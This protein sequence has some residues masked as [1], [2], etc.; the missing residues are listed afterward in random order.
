MLADTRSQVDNI[1]QVQLL[2]LTPSQFIDDRRK[3]LEDLPPN[4]PD[5][6]TLS[7]EMFVKL[8]AKEGLS[9]RVFPSWMHLA[10]ALATEYLCKHGGSILPENFGHNEKAQRIFSKPLYEFKPEI[11]NIDIG[12]KLRVSNRYYGSSEIHFQ[13]IDVIVTIKLQRIAGHVGY[14]N[15]EISVTDISYND[16]DAK[17]EDSALLNQSV[18]RGVPTL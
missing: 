15:P 13:P 17:L 12:V 9:F 8:I 6:Y 18:S 16:A 4:L 10:E 2:V 5:T 3:C 7:E 11:E 14:A 1:A